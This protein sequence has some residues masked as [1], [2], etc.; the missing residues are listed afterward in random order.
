MWL[1]GGQVHE[2]YTFPACTGKHSMAARKPS[3]GR[4]HLLAFPGELTWQTG[5]PLAQDNSSRHAAGGSLPHFLTLRGTVP[6]L[7]NASGS[8]AEP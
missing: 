6:P 3:A 5:S 2:N 8:L 4:L 1:P 7:T